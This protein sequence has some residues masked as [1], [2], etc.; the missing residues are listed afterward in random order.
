MTSWHW[1]VQPGQ[2]ED[3]QAFTILL[4]Y[5]KGALIPKQIVY[6]SVYQTDTDTGIGTI[7]PAK[8]PLDKEK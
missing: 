3:T 2:R 4:G 8:L 7:V 5:I 6:D 1:N